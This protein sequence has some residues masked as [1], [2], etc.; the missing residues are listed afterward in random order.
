MLYA[1]T[2]AAIKQQDSFRFKKILTI[3]AMLQGKTIKGKTIKGTKVEKNSESLYPQRI[4]E[5]NGKSF[6]QL[7]SSILWENCFF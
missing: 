7:G 2:Q 5:P 6:L 4:D 1:T 3:Q